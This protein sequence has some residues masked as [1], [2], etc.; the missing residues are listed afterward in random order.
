MAMHR[1]RYPPTSPS[2]VFS[3]FSR[4]TRLDPAAGRQRKQ[5]PAAPSLFSRPGPAAPAP[6][7]QL[8]QDSCQVS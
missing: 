1:H 3:L 5:D 8:L 6:A 2:L 4:A 7:P